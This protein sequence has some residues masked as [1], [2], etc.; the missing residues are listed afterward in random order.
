MRLDGHDDAVPEPVWRLFEDIAPRC[1]RLRGVT[2]E[3]MEGTVTGAADVT[4]LREELKRAR[5]VLAR[6]A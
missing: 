5:R 4:V 2:L 3:R 1:P 6:L